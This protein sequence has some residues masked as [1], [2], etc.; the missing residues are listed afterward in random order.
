VI[1][2]MFLTLI[3]FMFFIGA[4]VPHLFITMK[5]KSLWNSVVTHMK[6]FWNHKIGLKPRRNQHVQMNVFRCF[7]TISFKF[8]Q[9]K[10]L[11]LKNILTVD[12]V[13]KSSLSRKG[14]WKQIPDWIHV[15][16]DILDTSQ[17]YL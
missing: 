14:R 12:L 17:T 13:S 4:C 11:V 3:L 16:K 9:T 2:F 1:L 6:V 7:I 5:H 15:S 8:Q 10:I